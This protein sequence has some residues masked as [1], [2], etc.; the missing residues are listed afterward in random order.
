M[1]VL[2][3]LA[4]AEG[5][6]RTVCFCSFLG[7]SSL[8]GKRSLFKNHF[9]FSLSPKGFDSSHCSQLKSSAD[10]VQVDLD[11]NTQF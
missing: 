8:G 3:L 6:K 10:L 1:F 9:L 4:T 5:S 11:Q 2:N 7:L